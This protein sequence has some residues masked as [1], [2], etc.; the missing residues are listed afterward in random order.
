MSLENPREYRADELYFQT[1]KRQ[2]GSLDKISYEILIS[3][4]ASNFEELFKKEGAKITAYSRKWL[5]DTARSFM[6]DAADNNLRN[7]ATVKFLSD[8]K[9]ITNYTEDKAEDLLAESKRMAESKG[10]TGIESYK[11]RRDYISKHQDSHDPL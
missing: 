3:Q 4:M 8:G 9:I 2:L 1:M 10:L 7:D 11:F 6:E 5:V